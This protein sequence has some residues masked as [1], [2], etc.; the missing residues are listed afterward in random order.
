MAKRRRK[1]PKILLHP[2]FQWIRGK[3]GKIVYRLSQNGE[4]SAYPAPDMS[5]IEWSQPQKTQ[6]RSF[7]RAQAYTK[8]AIR[9]PEIRQYYVEMAKRRKKNKRRPGDMAMWDYFQG[10]DL[11]WHKFYG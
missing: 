7:A 5:N 9:D 11:L 2:M 3:M 8:L 6:R 4:V 1:V 10:N